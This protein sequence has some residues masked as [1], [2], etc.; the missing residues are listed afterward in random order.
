MSEPALRASDAERDRTVELL[1]SG[2]VDGRLTLE[3]FAQRMGSAYEARTREELDELTRDLPAETAPA[4][5]PSRRSASAKWV[6]AVMG[7]ADRRGRFRLGAQ[8]N[9]VTVMGGA[10]IDLRQAELEGPD[11]TITVVSVMGGTNIIVPEG[12][13]VDLTGFSIMG[14]RSYRRGR[15][16]VPPGAPVVRV[17][18]FSIMGGVSV[19]TKP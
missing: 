13:D 11:V 10:N 15:K 16:P 18:A 1:R 2:T 7:G 12:V 3:E 9:V 8:T 14:G 17:R 4:Q 6:V 19:V 5:F